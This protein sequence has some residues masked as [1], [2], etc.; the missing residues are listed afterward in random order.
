ME[1]KIPKEVSTAILL[2]VYR[3]GELTMTELHEKTKFSTITVLNHVNALLA[4]GLLEEERVG[5][6][7][8]K[9]VLKTSQEGKRIASLLNLADLS[10]HGSGDLIEMGAKAGR[11]AAYQEGIASLRRAKATKE[12]LIAELFLKGIGGLGG[13]ISS[14]AK[15]LPDPLAAE[16]NA[17][18]EWSKRLEAYYTEGQRL[19][20]AEDLNGC[21]SIVSKALAEFAGASKIF[22]DAA[23]KLKGMKLEELANYLEFLAPK[24]TQKE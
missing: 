2:A 11:V 3:S 4:A 6:F 12:W 8:K 20:G 13:G 7:P 16:K 17:L 19:L 18:I 5:N 22:S 10:C 15:G 14:A 1:G 23:Q 9:R 24:Q 21:I